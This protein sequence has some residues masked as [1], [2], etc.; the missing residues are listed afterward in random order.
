MFVRSAMAFVLASMLASPSAFA[1][2]DSPALMREPTG[3]T[4]V[5][6]AFDEHDPFDLNLS[7]GFRRS[8]ITSDIVRE[9]AGPGAVAGD[10]AYA[11]VASQRQLTNTLL[12]G[13]DIGIYRDLMIYG[14]LPVVLSDERQLRAAGST[15]IDLPFSVPFQSPTRSGLDSLTTGLAWSITNQARQPHL[16]T[17]LVMIE[18][19]FN[20]GKTLRACGSTD[21]DAMTA[22][23]PC[24]DTYR[25]DDT[26]N[27]TNDAGLTRGTHSLRIE[28]RAS[29]RV[30]LVEPYAGFAFEAE[31]LAQASNTFLPAGELAGMLRQ[32]PPLRADATVGL[33]VTPWEQQAHSQRLTLDFRGSVSYVSAGRDY[34]P[35]FDALGTSRDSSLTT[36]NY[37]VGDPQNGPASLRKSFFYGITD[38]QAHARIGG[39]VQLEMR[40]AR[41]VKFNIGAGLYYTPPYLI[42]AAD[43][44]N[45]SVSVEADDRRRGTCRDGIINPSYRPSIDLASRRFRVENEVQFD[46]SASVTASF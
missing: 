29:R 30:G 44:C 34:S 20:I 25:N 6:D 11:P 8:Q 21:L 18:G 22:G 5:L 27:Y 43:A 28:T 42:T 7:V 9:S 10:G 4:D 33:A 14:R 39:M 41:Y 31:F 32:N 40:A 19:R 1:D 16:P 38:V 12:V 45:A 23:T 15:L 37:E 26:P 36:P 35:L 46:V 13:V 2:E 17:W 3:Y 24:R